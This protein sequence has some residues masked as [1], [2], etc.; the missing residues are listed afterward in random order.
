MVLFRA[1]ARRNA[2]CADSSRVP[3]AAVFQRPRCCEG[4]GVAKV[5]VQKRWWFKSSF[6]L[7]RAPTSQPLARLVLAAQGTFGRGHFVALARINRDSIAQSPRQPL[8]TCFHH[9]VIVEAMQA[10]H[11]QRQP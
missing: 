9:M 10:V 4:R 6:D 7:C 5:V 3:K 11:M 8:E 2:I 1:I